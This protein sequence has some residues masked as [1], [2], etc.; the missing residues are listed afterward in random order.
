M[1][2]TIGSRIGEVIQAL[3][4][5]KVRFA[6]QIKVDQ[7]YITQLVNEK[8][9]PS[10]RTIADICREFHVNEDWLRTGEGEMFVEL[11]RDQEIAAFMGNVLRGESDNFKRRFIA[12][13][14]KL[15]EA[16]W[17]LLENKVRE[18]A[19]GMETK[20]SQQ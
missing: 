14:A 8:R 4:I 1:T 19:E 10:D 5:K 13:L 16:E 7:S 17:Q 2:G 9:N 6:E 3:G 15:N 11:T 18:L 12:M 20:K